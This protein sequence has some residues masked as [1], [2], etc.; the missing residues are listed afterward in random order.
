M[1]R[2]AMAILIISSLGFLIAVLIFY[3]GIGSRQPGPESPYLGHNA[4][5]VYNS[6]Y[7]A[8]SRL[9]YIDEAARLSWNKSDGNLEKF[10]LEFQKY[11]DNFNSMY[12]ADL[13][14]GD[15]ELFIKDGYLKGR[16]DKELK[17][18]SNF[19]S[20]RFRPVFRVAV[21]DAQ[22][23]VPSESQDVSLIPG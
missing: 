21:G 12:Y 15:Y 4:V 1:N 9:F 10:K 8:E 18:E 17:L 11:L 2:R 22:L 23:S 14:V 3:A 7:N 13:S 6:Y 19:V 20:Y 16:T 5:L